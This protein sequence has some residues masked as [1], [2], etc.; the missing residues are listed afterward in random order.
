MAFR[1]NDGDGDRRRD[2]SAGVGVSVSVNN[3]SPPSELIVRLVLLRYRDQKESKSQSQQ[4]IN[5]SIA[6]RSKVN[7]IRVRGECFT[8]LSIPLDIPSSSPASP[9]RGGEL[10][11]PLLQ[12]RAEMVH[13]VGHSPVRRLLG[14]E[15]YSLLTEVA[16]EL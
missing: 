5:Q 12:F 8:N 13:S 7:K 11:L 1:R 4:S 9:V 16:F 14:F 2:R 6:S 3:K 15:R 10:A